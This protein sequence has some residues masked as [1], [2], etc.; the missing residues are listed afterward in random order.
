MSVEPSKDEQHRIEVN[1]MLTAK[2]LIY[3]FSCSNFPFKSVYYLINKSF[4]FFT[5]PV[6]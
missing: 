2:Y 1:F 6:Y 4:F 5:H 3:K